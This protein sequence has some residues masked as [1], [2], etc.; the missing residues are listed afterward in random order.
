VRTSELNQLIASPEKLQK[1]QISD[2]QNLI[3]EYPYFTSAHLLLTKA[4]FESENLNFENQLRLSAAYAGDRKKL[5][6]LLYF[7]KGI[8]DEVSESTDG[9]SSDFKSTDLETI[10][11]QKTETGIIDENDQT[12]TSVPERSLRTDADSSVEKPEAGSLKL[13]TLEENA[14]LDPRPSDLPTEQR[15]VDEQ[16]Q[17]DQDFLDAQ[18]MSA[19]I[20][21]SIVDELETG[22]GNSESQEEVSREES[23]EKKKTE[24]D[25]A[26]PHS[27]SAWLRHYSG[28]VYQG[29]GGN[30]N[31]E[32]ESDKLK[33]NPVIKSIS[34]Q[35]KQIQEKA[36]FY[37]ASKMAKLSVTE[38]D[39][40]VTET[41]AKVFEDQGKYDKA[42]KAYEKLR[43]KFPE[44][45]VYFAGRINAVEK[46]LKS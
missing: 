25:E 21:N 37:S 20:G 5:H 14:G 15:E 1:E 11:S 30:G 42:I 3:S 6:D 31:L 19:A 40:L 38:S 28:A 41:L 33:S 13:D 27:F 2:L 4:F 22:V 16:A 9:Q 12:Q 17:A 35:A 46:K 24:F 23:E 18:V 8:G 10:D 36:E 44:K 32:S 43:L 45:S 39:D 26:A 34:D 7:G 29:E